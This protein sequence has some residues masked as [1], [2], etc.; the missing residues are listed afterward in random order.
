MHTLDEISLLQN[1]FVDKLS[2]LLWAAM[3]LLLAPFTKGY[4]VRIYPI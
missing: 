4:D 3:Y 1:Y 2:V